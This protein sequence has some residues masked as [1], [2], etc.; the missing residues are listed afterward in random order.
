MPAPCRAVHR[1]PL[2]AP[3]A[4]RR[5]DLRVLE[6]DPMRLYLGGSNECPLV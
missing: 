5:L 4:A 2:C 1:V 6:G 3:G